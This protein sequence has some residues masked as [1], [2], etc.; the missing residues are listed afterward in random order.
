[1]SEYFKEI[2]FIGS[3]PDVDGCPKN[4]LNEYAFIGRSNVGKSSLIN[5]LSNHASLAKTSKKPGKTQLINMF[6]VDDSWSMVDL[7]GY[8]YAVASKKNRHLWKK[9]I[10]GYL[11]SRDNLI[12]TFVLLDSRLELQ[13]ID[14]EF[15]NWLGSKGIP[16]SIIYTKIDGITRSKLDFHIERIQNALLEY[17]RELPPQFISSSTNKEGREEIME[18]ISETNSSLNEKK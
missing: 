3:F 14:L 2:K 11:E 6:N 5:Y 10:Y 13:K 17:W 1:M 4:K 16:F 18:F 15:I 9:M 8:G 7:P 12:N